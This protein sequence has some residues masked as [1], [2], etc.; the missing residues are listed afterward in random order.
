MQAVRPSL[1]VCQLIATGGTIAMRKDPSSGAA[2]PALSGEDLIA[3]VPGLEGL[4]AVELLNFSNVPSD[5]MDPTR[6]VALGRVVERELQR[7]GIAGAVISHGTDTLEEAAWFLDQTLETDKPAVIV[8]AQRN[9][10]EPD[11]DGPRNLEAGIRTC[12]ASAARGRGVLVVMND[13]I[14]SARHVTKSHTSAV[15]AFESGEAGIEGLVEGGQ[16]HFYRPAANRKPIPLRSELLPRVDIVPMY[17]GADGSHVQSAVQS[18]AKGV[19]IEAL[20][21]GNVNM[22]MYAA[23]VEAI[24]AQVVVVI[25]SRC[26]RGRVRPAYGFEGGGH[27]LHEAGALFAGDLSA[28]KA[29]ISTMLALQ[30]AMAPAEMQA[31]FNS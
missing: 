18:G 9:A 7:P 19:I 12:I 3:A 14:H 8:G 24:R 25:A 30:A 1:P 29:R 13:S 20:G 31:H 21:L 28:R 23:I 6:W 15:Q 17:A 4:A 26:G 27:S 10:S 5:Y 22:D 11:F 2:V 16:V